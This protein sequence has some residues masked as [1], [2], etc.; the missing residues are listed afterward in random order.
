M[1]SMLAGCAGVG[2]SAAAKPPILVGA[3]LSESGDFAA[4]GAAFLKGYQL[5]ADDVNAAGGLLGGRKVKLVVRNDASS[6]GQVVA[7]YRKLVTVDHVNLLFGPFSSKLT[8]PASQVANQY[9]YAFVEGAG[10]APAIFSN[11][12]QDL[13]DVSLPVK[14]SLVPFANWIAS[15]P[16]SQRPLTASY[17]SSTNIFTQPQ[18]QLIQQILQRDGIRTVYAKPFAESVTDFK[19]IAASV[20]GAGA[21]LVVLGSV[22]LPTVAAFIHAFA[23]R[24]YNPKIFIATAGPDQGATFVAT[25]K[26]A[27]TE[28][29]MVPNGWFP[30][31]RNAASE[32]MVSEYV[33]RHGGTPFGVNADVAEAYSVGQ[34]MAQ[35][36]TATGSLDNAKIIAYLHSGVILNSVQGPVQFDQTGQNGKPAAFIFQWQGGRF[37]QVL[38]AGAP[39]S[40]P[41]ENPKPPWAG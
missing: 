25:V 8:A 15:L 14:A 19:P 9:G 17:P 28:G 31:Y 21:Q 6:T 5:W 27:N 1:A 20:A 40:L 39:G 12:L 3:S 18:V 36:V 37:V 29:M 11:G 22:D 13:F 32:K 23:Q 38:P 35:A 16:A 10:G 7:N 34:V 24:H 33:A 4:D 26:A 2:G 41:I 30:G